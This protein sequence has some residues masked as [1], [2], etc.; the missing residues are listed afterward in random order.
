MGE[1]G[2]QAME[3]PHGRSFTVRQPVPLQAANLG[4]DE[5]ENSRTN[6]RGGRGEESAET[7]GADAHLVSELDSLEQNLEATRKA[8][9]ACPG[10]AVGRRSP[11]VRRGPA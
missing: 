1:H 7:S 6:L 2:A 3:A 11:A 9:E 10:G 5:A 4:A 8:V